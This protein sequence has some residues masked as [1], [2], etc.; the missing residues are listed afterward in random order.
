VVPSRR[1]QWPRQLVDRRRKDDAQRAERASD[2]LHLIDESF[3]EFRRSTF[4]LSLFELREVPP[5]SARNASRSAGSPLRLPARRRGFTLIELLVVIAIIAILIA[6][7]LPAVQQA[8]EA[9]RRTECKNK[10]KQLGLAMHNYHS[11]FEQFPL[12]GQVPQPRPNWRFTLLPYLEQQTIY[13][14]ANPIGGD[15]QSPYTGVSVVL[16]NLTVSAYACP[17]SSLGS[18]TNSGPTKNNTDLG[19]CHDY[20]G[21]AGAT[22]DPGGRSSVC[23]PQHRYGGITCMNGLVTPLA[24]TG[25]RDATDGTSN[26]LLIGEQSGPIN[27]QDYRSVYYGG[28]G[29][30]TSAFNNKN[31]TTWNSSTDAW[32]TGT[33]TI[34]YA[35][36][37]KGAPAT[38]TD[39][40]YDANTAL[41]S[42]HPG[43]TQVLIADGSVQFLSDN[44]NFTTL[45]RLAA[46]DDGQVVGNY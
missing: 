16:K 25:I 43:G 29:G 15:F 31:L 21:I 34:R 46:R 20:V 38:G 44:I 9:A 39:N 18:N 17:S 13:D 26:T 19:M 37:P 5:M 7:L 28:W 40:T 23:S 8:R 11:T 33:T 45:T 10:M 12:G 41:T 30:Y 22:P 42:S 6:L 3:V 27:K 24:Q 32:G 36:N 35:I 1:D 2:G 14:T 4:F